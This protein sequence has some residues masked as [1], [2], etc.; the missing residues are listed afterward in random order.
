M[1]K[2]IKVSF[3]NNH[4]RTSGGRETKPFQISCR[5]GKEYYFKSRAEENSSYKI[6]KNPSTKEGYSITSKKN[7]C[8]RTKMCIFF[9]ASHLFLRNEQRR[10]TVSTH[11]SPTP[12]APASTPSLQLL[13]APTA[14][15][16]H[17]PCNPFPLARV[18]YYCHASYITAHHL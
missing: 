10:A 5:R 13:P 18:P 3:Y 17:I 16:M 11:F 1:R 8:I 2:R 9:F 14:S 12:T 15:P 6:I 4:F 7:P